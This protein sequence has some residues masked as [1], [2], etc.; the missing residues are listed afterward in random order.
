MLGLVSSHFRPICEK[1]VERRVPLNS[2]IAKTLLHRTVID[3]F[4]FFDFLLAEYH[5]VVMT[6]VAISTFRQRP[7]HQE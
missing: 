4:D 3:I 2:F 6:N 1:S 5:V 7:L